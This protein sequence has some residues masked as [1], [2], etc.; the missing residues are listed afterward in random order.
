MRDLPGRSAAKT[1]SG[2]AIVGIFLRLLD[3]YQGILFLTT[4]RAEVLDHAVR[5]RVML[6]LDYPDLDRPARA[7]IWR[8]MLEAA[9]LTLTEGTV[10]ELAEAEL[11]G[12]QIRNLTRLARILHPDRR[13]TLD[14]MRHVLH[15]GSTAVQTTPAK[16]A[17]PCKVRPESRTFGQ[18]VTWG[19]E[20]EGASL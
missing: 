3:Y 19:R 4:N 20:P 13:V 17:T 15:Y 12:R 16:E 6:R 10:E 11:N 14:Q 18:P 9:G 2:S 5:S 7:A 8:T 1:W